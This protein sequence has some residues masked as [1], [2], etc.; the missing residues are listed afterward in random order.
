ML[1]D[2]F[3]KGGVFLLNKTKTN[4]VSLNVDF[5]INIFRGIILFV[6][7]LALCWQ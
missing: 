1:T 2:N 5:S 4:K 7:I 6:L 3:E